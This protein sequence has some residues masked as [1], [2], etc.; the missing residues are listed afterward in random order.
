[1]E[2]GKLLKRMT[3][4]QKYNETH[5]EKVSLWGSKEIEPI[6]EEWLWYGARTYLMF[7]TC[8]ELNE[9]APKEWEKW[10]DE[11]RKEYGAEEDV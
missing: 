9:S 11:E 10:F 7:I 6:L 1:L 2:E 8:D 4:Q 5:G 3:K